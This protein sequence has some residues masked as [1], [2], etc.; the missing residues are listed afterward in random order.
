M[1][2]APASDESPG[3][4]CEQDVAHCAAA[5]QHARGQIRQHHAAVAAAEAGLLAADAATKHLEARVAELSGRLQAESDA[6]EVEAACLLPNGRC[7]ATPPYYAMQCFACPCF[8][9]PECLESPG[10]PMIAVRASGSRLQKCSNIHD[11]IMQ[12]A[13]AALEILK[14]AEVLCQ[15]S[16]LAGSQVN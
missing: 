16:P 15:E 12:A 3:R 9:R 1:H 14:A 8:C 7:W 4:W 5:L 10:H 6:R 13:E 11:G 2:A